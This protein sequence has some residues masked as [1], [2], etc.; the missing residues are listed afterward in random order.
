M[1]V[2]PSPPHFECVYSNSISKFIIHIV[3]A[4]PSYFGDKTNIMLGAL[5]GTGQANLL[6]NQIIII[7]LIWLIH[8]AARM[9]ECAIRCAPNCGRTDIRDL[10]EMSLSRRRAKSLAKNLLYSYISILRGSHL[11]RRSLNKVN[12]QG[13]TQMKYDIQINKCGRDEERRTSSN[14]WSYRRRRRPPQN[15]YSTPIQIKSESNHRM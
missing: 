5:W 1:Q 13:E 14:L 2:K 11:F 15:T 8:Y 10:H 12:T 7:M 6:L 3:R 4:H 9:P